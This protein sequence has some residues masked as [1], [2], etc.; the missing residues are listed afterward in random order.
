[1]TDSAHLKM[2]PNWNRTIYERCCTR[3]TPAN[4]TPLNST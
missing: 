4:T 3:E 1:M 2:L